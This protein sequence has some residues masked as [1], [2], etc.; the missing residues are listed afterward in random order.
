MTVID[1]NGLIMGRLASNVAKRLLSGEK[2]AIVNAE[3]AVISGSKA[4]TFGEYDEI[5]NI[6]T[7]EFGPYFPKRPDRILKRTVRGML[8]Y[9]RARGKEAMANLKIHVGIPAEL[10]D[11]ELTT[12]DEA[13]MTR[14]SSIK[15]VTIG[16]VSRK[17]GAKF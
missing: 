4:T 10:K 8:P 16:D 7:R 14:L 9:K 2:I 5:M 17:L 12:V 6:G 3:Y 11:E 13:N 1:A 15:Y